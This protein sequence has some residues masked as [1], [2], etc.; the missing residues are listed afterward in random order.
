M[1]RY[2]EVL[3]EWMRG[4]G[5]D[6]PTLGRAAGVSASLIRKLRQGRREPTPRAAAALARHGAPMPAY[7]ER[8]G[9]VVA[10]VMTPAAPQQAA[11]APTP[12]CRAP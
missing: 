9:V 10:M 2:G 4:Q 11:A 3:G 7:V 8:D 12:G 1:R 6:A 5:L